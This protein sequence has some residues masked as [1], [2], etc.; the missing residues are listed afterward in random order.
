MTGLIRSEPV[1]FAGVIRGWLLAVLGLAVALGWR[2]DV[3]AITAAIV[4][5]AGAVEIT[6][7]WWSRAAVVPKVAVDEQLATATND[8]HVEGY[9]AALDDVT[10]LDPQKLDPAPA[11]ARRKA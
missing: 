8:A 2:P 3:N 6:T 10:Q 7:T 1:G 9:H 5:I 4:S 11:R